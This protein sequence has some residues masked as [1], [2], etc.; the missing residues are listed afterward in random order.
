MKPFKN[1]LVDGASFSYDGDE[2]FEAKAVLAAIKGFLRE[3]STAYNSLLCETG[4]KFEDPFDCEMDEDIVLSVRAESV[5][6]GYKENTYSDHY[7]YYIERSV[8]IPLA[9]FL[10]WKDGG[11]L[12]RTHV[13]DTL[14]AQIEKRIA[15]T[16]KTLSGLR[17]ALRKI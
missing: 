15:S 9:T 10:D 3:C 2:T 16:D 6:L 7:P 4:L 17:E 5:I 11:A 1:I 12:W 8:T 14:K 13:R